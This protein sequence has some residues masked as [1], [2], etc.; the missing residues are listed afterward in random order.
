MNWNE[1]T[2]LDVKGGILLV[3][4]AMTLLDPTASAPEWPHVRCEPG[5]YVMEINVPDPVTCHRVRIKP[6]D[7]EPLL[8]SEIGTVAVDHGFVGLVDYESFLA[9]VSTDPEAYEEWTGM[10][11][12]DELAINFSG[13]IAFSGETLLYVKAGEGDGVYRVYALESDGD[14]VGLECVFIG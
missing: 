7:R 4:D 9:V 5:E 3:K 14:I 11:L 13:E 10:E 1:V 12:D 2:R 6:S 8:G